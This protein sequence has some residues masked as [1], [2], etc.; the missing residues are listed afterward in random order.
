MPWEPTFTAHGD[1]LA[2]F[3]HLTLSIRNFH[4]AGDTTTIRVPLASLAAL[5]DRLGRYEP[6]ATIAGFAVSPLTSTALPEFNTAITHLRDVLGDPAYESLAR[7]GE[8]MTTAAMVTYAYD[9]IDQAR[10]ALK[11]VSK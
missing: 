8:H 3:G 7:A 2:A 4:N 10:A 11:A 6:A 1:T 5:F 9:Q